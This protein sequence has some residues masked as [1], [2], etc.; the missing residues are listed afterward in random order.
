[1]QLA[2]KLWTPDEQLWTPDKP[3]R[4]HLK[5]ELFDA[6]TGKLQE[7]V[8][9]DNYVTDLLTAQLRYYARTWLHN[10]MVGIASPMQDYGMSTMV[11][12]NPAPGSGGTAFVLTDA[13]NAEDATNDRI[14]RGGLT[15]FSY[16][17]SYTGSDIYRGQLNVNESSR[18]ATKDIYV[19]DW[20]T[21][22][23][24]GTISSV[25]LC[26][27]G[28]NFESFNAPVQFPLFVQNS[29]NTGYGP[30]WADSMTGLTGGTQY[31]LWL[32]PDGVSYWTIYQV[33][34]VSSA[35][36]VKRTLGT[37][38]QVSTVSCTGMSANIVG[39]FTND[40]VGSV[41]NWWIINGGV[42][43]YKFPAAG[44]APSATYTG[45]P[46]YGP[47]TFGGGYVYCLR[48]TAATFSIDQYLPSTGALV[49]TIALGVMPDAVTSVSGWTVT[50]FGYFPDAANGDTFYCGYKNGSYNGF[51][52][53]R[54]SLSGVGKTA[55]WLGYGWGG[56]FNYTGVVSGG[57][58]WD[59]TGAMIETDLMTYSP[60]NAQG[61]TRMNSSREFLSRSLLPSPVVKSNTQTMKLTYE[62]DYS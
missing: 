2:D 44:G 25:Y 38:A 33:G 46:S 12:N 3:I 57:L 10:S 17:T 15:A 29:T 40:G 42:N 21:S 6:K 62:Y 58:A 54:Y 4:G 5:L 55:L 41:G 31:G 20:P 49:T 61:T 59:S 22:A 56:P 45:K 60:V 51:I 26:T 11:T 37:G 34:A 43:L 14:V 13:T 27:M 7:R 18:Q 24:N 36:L 53:N 1:M 32:D 19:I 50:H 16:T 30:V 47:M 8:E 9:A 52:V 48:I 35:T 39:G 23:G 28:L